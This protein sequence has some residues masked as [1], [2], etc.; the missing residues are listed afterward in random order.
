M[1]RLLHTTLGCLLHEAKDM[2]PRCALVQAGVQRWCGTVCLGRRRFAARMKPAL[3]RLFI[4][5]LSE[6]LHNCVIC[7]RRYVSESVA[8]AG[9]RR[10]LERHIRRLRKHIRVFQKAKWR[11][12]NACLHS[13]S[14]GLD[15]AGNKLG[16]TQLLENKFS[17]NKQFVYRTRAVPNV[18]NNFD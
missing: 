10:G 11:D 13:A 12:P 8:A 5:K 4:L 3:L 1:K 9:G 2:L 7:L 16:T 15:A 6:P 14:P 17:F 18:C